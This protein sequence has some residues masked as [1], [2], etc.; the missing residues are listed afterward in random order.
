MSLLNYAPGTPEQEVLVAI[1]KMF[2]E[3]TE[4]PLT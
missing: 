4:V 3:Q 1:K 2:N